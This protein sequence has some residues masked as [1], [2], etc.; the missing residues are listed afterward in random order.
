M[1]TASDTFRLISPAFEDGKAMPTKFAH[2]GVPGGQN[3][4]VPLQWKNPPPGTKSF[5]LACVD[6]HPIAN[7]WVHWMV[8]D[9]PGDWSELVEGASTTGKMPQGC[10]ELANTFGGQGYGGPQ[11]PRGS[12]PHKY[13]FSLYALN[14][15]RLG[16]DE[17]TSLSSLL[18]VIGGKVIA[19]A[20]VTG[21]YER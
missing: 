1:A 18:G 12:G 8:I 7:K 10:K 4:S 6:L 3:V 17:N 14:T 2:R 15:E 11:P 19:T 5:A 13:E 21:L 20:R 16:F 9:I